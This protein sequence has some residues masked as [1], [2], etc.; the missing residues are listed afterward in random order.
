[1]AARA[2]HRVKIDALFLESWVFPDVSAVAAATGAVLVLFFADRVG[3]SMYAMAG[4]A[5]DV[6]SVVNAAQVDDLFLPHLFIAMTGQARGYLFLPG[7]KTVSPIK[8]GQWRKTLA[9]VRT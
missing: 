1:M 9:T 4:R 8:L 2:G 3:F 5:I 6:A 7:G